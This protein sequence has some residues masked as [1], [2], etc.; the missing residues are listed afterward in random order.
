MVAS[1]TEPTAGLPWVAVGAAAVVEVTIV[2]KATV[3][4]GGAATTTEPRLDSPVGGGEELRTRGLKLRLPR[5]FTVAGLEKERR[6]W[7]GL[8]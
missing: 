1:S 8:E 6:G 3:V 4:G 2:A 7:D 5:V